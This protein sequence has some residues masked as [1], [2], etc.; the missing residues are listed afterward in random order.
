MAQRTGKRANASNLQVRSA[1]A[2]LSA[3]SPSDRPHR[4]C[5]ATGIKCV[6]GCRSVYR[7]LSLHER[8]LGLW[9]HSKAEQGLLLEL[10][11]DSDCIAGT[12]LLYENMW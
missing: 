2:F 5:I 8:S 9:R 1:V 10:Y 11:W 7:L 12:E 3:P 4:S 6:A